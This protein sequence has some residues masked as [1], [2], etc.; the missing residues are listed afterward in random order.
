[1]NYLD[2]DNPKLWIVDYYELLL[3]ELDVRVETICEKIHLNEVS[4][5]SEIE[6]ELNRIRSQFVKEIKRVQERNLLNFEQKSQSFLE[7]INNKGENFTRND[8]INENVKEI[9]FSDY[10]FFITN[11]LDIMLHSNRS[12]RL[13]LKLITCDWYLNEN[14]VENL[15][16]LLTNSINEILANEVIY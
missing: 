14:Q 16:K 11:N 12:T 13:G 8:K 4:N 9:I 15:R 2:Q 6:N 10:C 7:K 5:A 1:M 3:N